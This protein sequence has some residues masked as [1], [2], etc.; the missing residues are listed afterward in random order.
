MPACYS[1]C[2]A[3]SPRPD[4]RAISKGPRIVAQMN[5]FIAGSPA[6]PDWI[7]QELQSRWPTL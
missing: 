4:D 2:T 6:W 7:P 3:S 1:Q 5:G